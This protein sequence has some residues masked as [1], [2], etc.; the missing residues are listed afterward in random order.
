MKRILFL[1]TLQFF[2]F[3]ICA[4][5]TTKKFQSYI[6]GSEYSGQSIVL[7]ENLRIKLPF[8]S[9]GSD[10]SL[11]LDIYDSYL[12]PYKTL[13]SILQPVSDWD[14]GARVRLIWQRGSFSFSVGY[15]LGF[16]DLL[17]GS[18]KAHT[19]AFQ[20]GLTISFGIK[21]LFRVVSLNL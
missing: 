9:G 13:D 15:V 14:A 21:K 5:E 12:L 17:P 6:F 4:Q 8:F 2:A 20:I 10:L 1:L 7:D 18:D 19:N 3:S 16:L 11:D